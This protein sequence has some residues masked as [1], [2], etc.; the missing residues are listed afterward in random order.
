MDTKRLFSHAIFV[1]FSLQALCVYGESSL[2]SGNLTLAGPSIPVSITSVF[3]GASNFIFFQSTSINAYSGTSCGG[4]S[5]ETHT[6]SSGMF[7][8]PGNVTTTAYLSAVNSSPLAIMLCPSTTSNSIAIS[9]VQVTTDAPASLACVATGCV[10][11]TCAG[12]K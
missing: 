9:L 12:G 1:L 10:S 11:A 5:I 3:S 8:A 7:R 2:W 6:W 4:A